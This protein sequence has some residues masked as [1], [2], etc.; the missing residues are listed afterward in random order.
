MSKIITRND[1]CCILVE[2]E[3]NSP[4]IPFLNGII[5]D[6]FSK[7][8]S[9]FE[10]YVIE[11]GGSSS[12]KPFSKLCY[13]YSKVHEEIPV[14]AISD[15]D[16]RVRYKNERT[17]S[18]YIENKEPK[19][20]YWYRHE[21]ENYLLNELDFIVNWLK[22]L[23]TSSKKQKASRKG[24]ITLSTSDLERELERYFNSKVKEEF[25]ECLKFNLS[26]NIKKYP[27]IKKPDN[28][29]SLS[30]TNDIKTWFN[31]ESQKEQAEFKLKPKSQDLFETIISDFSW[32]NFLDNRD[33]VS[34]DVGKK[35]F[36]GKEAFSHLYSFLHQQQPSFTLYNLSKESLI[37][38]ILK[39]WYTKQDSSI[40]KDLESLLLPELQSIIRVR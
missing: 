3:P 20:L 21:W 7:N 25:W 33:T 38:E 2:G 39:N 36:R 32:S 4:E 24:T 11:V 16:Y 28:F 23:P 8:E 9:R 22:K 27:S 29:D 1:H 18:D 35:I 34:L 5:A 26:P 15:N 6:I 12:F 17:H 19:I 10:P 14:L 13:R 40:Y 30:S 31:S 37:K